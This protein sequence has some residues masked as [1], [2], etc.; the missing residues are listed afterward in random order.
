M[1][2]ACRD[3]YIARGLSRQ[4]LQAEEERWG[5]AAALVKKAS[6]LLTRAS[7]TDCPGV[8]LLPIGT[9]AELQS[10]AATAENR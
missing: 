1:G 10:H 2:L 5:L 8:R 7:D 6:D 4:A 9:L 3:A